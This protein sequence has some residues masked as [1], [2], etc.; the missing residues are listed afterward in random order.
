MVRLSEVV[1]GLQRMAEAA[2]DRGD[3]IRY[4][5]EQEVYDHIR[6]LDQ[7]LEMVEKVRASLLGERQRFMP[8]KKIPEKHED[9][10]PR[11]ATKGPAT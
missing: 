4:T 10:I 1:I 3:D 6:W 5:Q 11:I 2:R 8:V 7:Q 9:Q